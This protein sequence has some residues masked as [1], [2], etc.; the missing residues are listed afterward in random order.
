MEQNVR[1][2]IEEV[3]NNL[4]LSR[5]LVGKSGEEALQIAKEMGYDLEMN[6]LEKALDELA[7]TQA[8]AF[9]KKLSVDD[10]F[11]APF[12][13]AENKQER[14]ALLEKAGYFCK[15]EH[16]N[17]VRSELTMDDIEMIELSNEELQKAA[18]GVWCGQTHEGEGVTPS[19]QTSQAQ[20]SSL[21]SDFM[22]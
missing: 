7:L 16:V 11:A 19:D 3:E 21:S 5:S 1:K 2:F 12:R 8:R 10:L 4:D 14:N 18:G 6:N 22:S 13:E 20:A 17:Q 9:V 15:A